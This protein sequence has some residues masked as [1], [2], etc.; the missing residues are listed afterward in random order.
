MSK[1]VAEVLVEQ[2]TKIAGALDS[3]QKLGL[4]RDIIVLYIQKKTRLSQRDIIAV[5]DALKDFQ[6]QIRLPTQT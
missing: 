5:L 2:V 3:L 4:P 1:T 6:R